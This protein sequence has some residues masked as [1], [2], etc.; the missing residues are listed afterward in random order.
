MK[1]GGR[2]GAGGRTAL[3][4]LRSREPCP[5][6]RGCLKTRWK[7]PE[8]LPV[9]RPDRQVGIGIQNRNERRR[10]GT[11]P[12]VNRWKRLYLQFLQRAAPSA[13]MVNN[14]LIP[15]LR[16]GLFIGGP[17]GLKMRTDYLMSSFETASVDLIN[18]IFGAVSW[19][20]FRDT[21]GLHEC[22]RASR[23]AHP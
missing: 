5:I 19:G 21:G 7:R 10:C 20:A 14:R 23:S 6:R 3:T 2:V 9:H 1:M 22:L 4:E 8:G 11:R 17:S 15:A 18:L 13:L 16:P 12:R